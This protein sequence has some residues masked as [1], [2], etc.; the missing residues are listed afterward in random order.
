MRKLQKTAKKLLASAFALSLAV[1]SLPVISSTTAFAAESKPLVNMIGKVDDYYS[2][3]L[4]CNDETGT[5]FTFSGRDVPGCVWDL[6]MESDTFEKGHGV[7]YSENMFKQYSFPD[8][9]ITKWKSVS[10]ADV[11]EVIN[12]GP[13]IWTDEAGEAHTFTCIK[14][15]EDYVM[16]NYDVTLLNIDEI[17]EE[18]LPWVALASKPSTEPT[19][20]TEP[21][22]ERLTRLRDA[23]Y[24]EDGRI[25]G[26]YLY[27]NTE[28]GTL[29]TFYGYDMPSPFMFWLDDSTG[30]FDVGAKF[31]MSA[32]T[33]ENLDFP[34]A[35]IVMR[36]GEAGSGN[37]YYDI[38]NY[39][40]IVY[41]DEAGESHTFTCIKDVEDYLIQ[42]NLVTLISSGDT[43]TTT[44]AP[45]NIL[46]G[47]VTMDGKV[48]LLDAIYL[49]KICS[50]IIFPTDMQRIAGD[51]NADGTVNDVDVDRLMDFCIGLQKK[52]PVTD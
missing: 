37:E 25:Y 22:K 46:I 1:T 8:A 48:D 40:D 28:T 17:P 24:S 10:N 42:S 33:K 32:R 38:T 51:C 39:G 20:P 23:G 11:Y 43:T 19:T 2:L 7:C 6:F 50:N 15:V 34:N 21:K 3:W 16:Q 4:Y 31:T 13:I 45:S 29:F 27:D 44:T 52:L 12:Y 5:A 30:V 9:E 49:N 35:D 18:K 41:T 26:L 47:D 36:S 14:D